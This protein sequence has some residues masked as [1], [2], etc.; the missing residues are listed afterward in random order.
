[1]SRWL[2]NE[3]PAVRNRQPL[4]R[5]LSIPLPNLFEDEVRESY[6][7]IVRRLDRE[8][9]TVTELLSPSNK[10]G[11]GRSMYLAK[12]N[13]LIHQDVNLVELDLLRCGRRLPLGRALPAGDYFALVA[14]A[15]RRPQ[16][17]VY[18]R[19]LRHALPTIPIPLRAPDADI[20]LDLAA[21]VAETY[22]RG[23]YARSLNYAD[24]PVGVLGPEELQWVRAQLAAERSG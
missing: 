15:A 10:S 4:V 13:A 5:R 1:M 21:L 7:R 12:R 19:T 20:P 23:R 8:L 18:A 22:Q 17:D 9:V 3:Y 16:C 6:V 11:G 24:S 2:G 14:R